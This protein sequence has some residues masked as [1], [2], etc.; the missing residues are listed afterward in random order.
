MN[1]FILLLISFCFGY[2]GGF[3]YFFIFNNKEKYLTIILKMLY[4][5][6]LTLLYITL[7]YFINEGV[8]H[9]YMK[10][11]LIIGFL[12]S[13]F[14]SNLCKVKKYKGLNS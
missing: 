8:V 5:L 3:F 10:I 12:L 13:L 1:Q 9:L 6:I 4:F 2:I 11:L 7:I 14:V